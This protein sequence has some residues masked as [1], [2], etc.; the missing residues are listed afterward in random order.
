MFE[1]AEFRQ[2][3]PEFSDTAKYPDSMITFW[4]EV[5]EHQVVERRWRRMTEKG[6]FLYVAH[7][8]TLASQNYNS[9]NIGGTPG[10]SSGPVKFQDRGQCHCLI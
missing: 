6:R 2:A 1:I 7:E 3:F 9:G 8:I 5:A 10:G 4:G